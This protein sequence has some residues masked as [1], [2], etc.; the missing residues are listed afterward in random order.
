LSVDGTVTQQTIR[1]SG[2]TSGYVDL[3]APAV[4]GSNN[5]VL[6]TGN[7]TADQVLAGNGS[8]ALSWI[9]PVGK[10]SFACTTGS[11]TLTH[12]TALVITTWTDNGIGNFDSSNTF[13]TSNG[14]FTP[15]VSGYYFFSATFSSFLNQSIVFNNSIAF[16]KNGSSVPNRSMYMDNEVN[17]SVYNNAM[18]LNGVIELNGST[19]YVDVTVGFFN[20]TNATNRSCDG[21]AFQGFLLSP[22]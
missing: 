2:S 1:L 9:T 20:Y 6:P 16:R 14:R 12:N 10:P 4:A 3:T 5:L 13:D 11:F 21:G 22:T 7:G 8:G 15:Q 19:D 17:G 18:T